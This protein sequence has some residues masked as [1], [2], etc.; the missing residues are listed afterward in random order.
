MSQSAKRINRRIDIF[1]NVYGLYKTII[2][3]PDNNVKT[4]NYIRKYFSAGDSGTG[5]NAEMVKEQ[6]YEN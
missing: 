1:T 5:L 3:I 6:L 2:L 4:I